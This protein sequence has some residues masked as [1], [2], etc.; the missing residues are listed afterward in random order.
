MGG[1]TSVRGYPASETR[2]DRGVFG[3]LG[4]RQPFQWADARMQGRIFIDSGRVWLVDQPAGAAD[5]DSLTSVGIGLDAALPG[6][7]NLKFDW[8]FPRDGDADQRQVSD[9]RKHGRLFGSLTVGF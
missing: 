3:T 9:D 8:A 5:Q 6:N 2:G 7:M 4:L 1:P